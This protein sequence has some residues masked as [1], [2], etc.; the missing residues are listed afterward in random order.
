MYCQKVNGDVDFSINEWNTQYGALELSNL[1]ETE[2]EKIL[3]P[4]E[5]KN[6][7]FDC[8]AIIGARRLR[9]KEI[10]KSFKQ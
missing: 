10:I 3:H 4:P 1:S 9:T 7:C 2:K 5:C 6:Q 8:M